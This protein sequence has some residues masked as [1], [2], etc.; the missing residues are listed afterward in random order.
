MTQPDPLPNGIPADQVFRLQ[1]GRLTRIGGRP[2]GPSVAA[3]SKRPR[4]VLSLVSP[5]KIPG[6]QAMPIRKASK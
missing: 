3:P 6:E 5:P 1:G 2:G 4:P